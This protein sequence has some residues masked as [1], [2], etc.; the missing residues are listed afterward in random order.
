MNVSTTQ[1]NGNHPVYLS[2]VNIAD[3]ICECCEKQSSTVLKGVTR[4]VDELTYM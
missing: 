2:N 4:Y 3:K 1:Q